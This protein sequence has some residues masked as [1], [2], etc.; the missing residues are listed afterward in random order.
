MTR[1]VT[2][3]EGGGRAA[4]PARHRHQLWWEAPPSE[5]LPPPPSPSEAGARRW[6]CGLVPGPDGPAAPRGAGAG[7]AAGPAPAPSP[8]K[9]CTTRRD[10][11]AHRLQFNGHLQPLSLLAAC[12]VTPRPGAGR[13]RCR[14][15]RHRRRRRGGGRRGGCRPAPV[16]RAGPA[17]FAPGRPSAGA[18]PAAG[19]ASRAARGPGGAP[20]PG[21]P[22]PRRVP[23][24]NNAGARHPLR[25]RDRRRLRVTTPSRGL[26]ESAPPRQEPPAPA[27][28]AA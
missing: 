4:P 2:E 26:R 18:A 6:R 24:I 13:G 16:I 21:C 17:A 14:P 19:R 23:D 12:P 11:P 8:G 7:A 3:T 15:L 22:R 10:L 9:S 20:Q 1:P 27:A 28:G 5:L 25:R